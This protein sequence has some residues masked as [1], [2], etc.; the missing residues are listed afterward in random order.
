[1]HS[2][3][4]FLFL[5]LLWSVGILSKDSAI[6]DSYQFIKDINS[7]NDLINASYSITGEI[8]KKIKEVIDLMLFNPKYFESGNS[9]YGE[10]YSFSNET[11]NLEKLVSVCASKEGGSFV[12]Y[13]YKGVTLRE[14]TP[15]TECDKGAY[16]YAKSYFFHSKYPKERMIYRDYESD[17]I[18]L[19]AESDTNYSIHL[20]TSGYEQKLER[21]IIEDIPLP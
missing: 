16:L 12:S 19:Y 21:L 9:K 18:V 6:D 2:K 7:E 14:Q 11:S 4:V 5:S 15:R 3:T 20:L 17:T 10:N 1:M 13:L 8:P